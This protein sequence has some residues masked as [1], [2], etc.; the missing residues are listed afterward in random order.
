MISKEI[1]KALNNQISLEGYA[2][3]LYLSMAAW[4]D[5]QGLE[6]C[7]SFLMDQSDEERFHMLKIYEYM[8]EVDGHARTPKIDQPPEDFKSVKSLFELL[9]E[10][11][12]KVTQS[13]H[14]LVDLAYSEKDYTTLNFLQWYVEEQREEED[15][16]RSILDKIDLIGDSPQSLYF[17]D[18]ELEKISGDSSD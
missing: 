11:E 14:D 6:G 5:R 8:S 16:A 15:M 17:I 13:I 7:K 10:H 2:S 3:H 4:C 9:Y 1:E 18:I 12:Q